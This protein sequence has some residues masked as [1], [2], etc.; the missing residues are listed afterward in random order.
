[1][2]RIEII[3]EAVKNIP[4]EI[5]ERYPE[6]PR[7]KIAGMQDILIH[8]YCGIDLELA[9]EVVVSDLPDLKKKILKIR[10]ELN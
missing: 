1:M 4:E 5:K 10:E 6:I 2:R 7:K 8:E 3:G 9:W